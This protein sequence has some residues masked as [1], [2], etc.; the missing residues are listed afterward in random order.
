MDD[1]ERQFNYREFTVMLNCLNQEMSRAVAPSDSRFRPD[2]RLWEEGEETK[3][4]AE[5]IR[6]ENL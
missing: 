3:A 5:K 6:I 4:D 2:Q 1:H